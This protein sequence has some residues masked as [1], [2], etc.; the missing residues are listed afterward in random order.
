MK[1]INDFRN[2]LQQCIDQIRK[3]RQKSWGI[4]YKGERVNFTNT[5]VIDYS[6]QKKALDAMLRHGNFKYQM[7]KYV[8]G[9][10]YD[11]TSYKDAVIELLQSGELEIKQ[12]I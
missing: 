11:L 4:F 3:N 1:D 7:S 2:Y 6:S 10:G 9:T 5:D 8:P 12:L